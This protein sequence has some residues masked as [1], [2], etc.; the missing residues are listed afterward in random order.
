MKSE[1][2]HE[3]QH[4]TLDEEL[5]QLTN[6]LKAQ[7]TKLAAV[8]LIALVTVLVIVYVSRSGQ[9]RREA[10]LAEYSAL[11][12]AD[13]NIPFEDRVARLEALA[14]NNVSDRVAADALF[15]LG[16]DQAFQALM[17]ADPNEQQDSYDQAIEYYRRVIE[18]YP[19][20]DVIVA[21]AHL[22]IGLIQEGR[23]DYDAAQSSYNAVV[24][25]QNLEGQPVRDLT[26]GYL[27][28]LELYRNDPVRLARSV[29]EDAP[30]P[31]LPS[32]EAE[33]GEIM[34]IE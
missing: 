20:Q 16:R 10:V 15:L 34:N 32:F 33:P 14:G 30:D 22:G 27:Q 17:S 31:N 6:F 2:R 29:P 9:A 21:K 1:R 26:E 25:M 4:N 19:Q 23:G 13:Q 8:A 24:A 18:Q 7:G 3:L 11:T 5:A 28:A 12:W